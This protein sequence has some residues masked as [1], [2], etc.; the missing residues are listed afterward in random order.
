MLKKN[1]KAWRK[2]RN[3]INVIQ[4]GSNVASDYE[5]RLL[6]MS[7]SVELCKQVLLGLIVKMTEKVGEGSTAPHAHMQ[8]LP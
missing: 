7:Q 1:A 4:L 2:I 3:C 6:K 5:V 8:A